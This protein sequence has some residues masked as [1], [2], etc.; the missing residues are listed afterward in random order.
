MESY[1]VDRRIPFDYN[2]SCLRLQRKDSRSCARS[3]QHLHSED[4]E[5]KDLRARMYLQAGRHTDTWARGNKGELMGCI[6]RD[7]RTLI[8][9]TKIS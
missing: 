2:P 6:K 5:R 4:F 9:P 3:V 8:R 7:V 1:D